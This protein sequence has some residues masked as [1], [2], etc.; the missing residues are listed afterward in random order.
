[1]KDFDSIIL[2]TSYAGSIE[3]FVRIVQHDTIFIEKEEHYLKQTYR[4]RTLIATSN[5]IFPLI[6]PVIRKDGNHTKI[7]DVHISYTENWQQLQWRT[8][9]S[10]YSNSPYFLYYH[11]NLIPFYETRIPFL[12][13]YN[14]RLLEVILKLLG[15]NKDFT[16]TNSYEKEYETSILDL[17][18]SISP[19]LKSG[20][21]FAPYIQAFDVKYGFLPNLGIFDL[22]FNEGPNSLN[23]LRKIQLSN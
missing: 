22:L 15:I 13:D 5:G 2:S 23:Y 20:V 3:Y 6:I 21:N 19:K 7:K 14:S 10:A 12:L 9:V 18:N 4:N 17:R 1:M 11:D 16:F 8:I